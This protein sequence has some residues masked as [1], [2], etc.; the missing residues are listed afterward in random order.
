MV[1]EEVAVKSMASVANRLQVTYA[2]QKAV[3]MNQK[4][5]IALLSSLWW[6]RV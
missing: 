2:R 4:T 1:P 6:E 3:R 5:F